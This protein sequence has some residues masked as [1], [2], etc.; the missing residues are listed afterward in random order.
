MQKAKAFEK[1]RKKKKKGGGRGREGKMKSHE[2]TERKGFPSRSIFSP[3]VDTDLMRI[4]APP[5]GPPSHSLA[6]FC[7]TL[8]GV[9]H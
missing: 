8:T 5:D 2:G 1:E 4:D 6:F 7:L 3:T 9:H